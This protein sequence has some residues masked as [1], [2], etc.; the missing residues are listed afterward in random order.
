MLLGGASAR[1]FLFHDMLVC[2]QQ[3]P[4]WPLKQGTVTTGVKITH[5]NVSIILFT[6]DIVNV[7]SVPPMVWYITIIVNERLPAIIVN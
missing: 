7:V 2:H 6:L 3:E 1:R 5:C 4:S